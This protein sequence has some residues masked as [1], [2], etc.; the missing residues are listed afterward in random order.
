MCC[1]HIIAVMMSAAKTNYVALFFAKHVKATQKDEILM[2]QHILMP[3]DLQ[4]NT[5]LNK[6]KLI[7]FKITEKVNRKRPRQSQNR[8]SK[9]ILNQMLT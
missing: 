6:S 8:Q 7:H 3:F 2:N 5:F 1:Q 4:S 9:V